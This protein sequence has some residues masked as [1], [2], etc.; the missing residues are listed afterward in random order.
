MTSVA[1]PVQKIGFAEMVVGAENTD[2]ENLEH[3]LPCFSVSMV[4][5]CTVRLG[6]GGQWAVVKVNRIKKAG[7]LYG[8]RVRVRTF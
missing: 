6:C 8:I 3:D 1:H 4:G 5:I 7:W 2:S